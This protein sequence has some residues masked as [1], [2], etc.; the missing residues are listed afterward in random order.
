[1]NYVSDTFDVVIDRKRKGREAS[2]VALRKWV[3]E[4]Q[5]KLFRQSQ[6]DSPAEFLQSTSHSA[7]THLFSY[8]HPSVG[9]CC[10]SPLHSSTFHL[11]LHPHS[12]FVTSV[13]DRLVPL[14]FPLVRLSPRPRARI[15]TT[16]YKDL[17]HLSKLSSKTRYPTQDYLSFLF[18]SNTPSSW[19]L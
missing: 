19:L 1:M 3:D 12:D 11:I 6:G 13:Q 5:K 2:L 10:H 15:L 9:I 4:R 16:V 14:C 18:V 17:P 8:P 7:P